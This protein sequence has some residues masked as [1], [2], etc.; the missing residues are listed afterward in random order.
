MG[1][2]QRCNGSTVEVPTV[3]A[4]QELSMRS[5][6]TCDTREW[7]RGDEVIDLRE[8]LDLTAEASP[9][10]RRGRP[11]PGSTPTHEDQGAAGNA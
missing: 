9:K 1:T 4:G 8:V 7:R 3:V 5:C 6:S 2:C 10:S 11:A